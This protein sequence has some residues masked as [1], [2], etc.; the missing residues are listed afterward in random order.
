MPCFRAATLDGGRGCAR[1][2]WAGRT[3]RGSGSRAAGGDRKPS[4]ADL[5]SV[6]WDGVR[7]DEGPCGTVWLGHS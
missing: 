7:K 3:L 6:P 2:G 4:D 5:F 1:R